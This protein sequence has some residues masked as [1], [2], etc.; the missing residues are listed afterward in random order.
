MRGQGAHARGAVTVAATLRSSFLDKHLDPASSLGEILFGLIMTLTFTLGAGLMLREEGREGARELLIATIGCNV[1]WGIIDGAL[2]MVGQLFERG[3][4]RRVVHAVREAP[5]AEAGVPLLAGEL[6]ELLAAVTTD[7]ERSALYRRIA[8][9][10][11]AA[12]LPAIGVTR[13][14]WLGGVASFFLVFFA[15]LPAAFPFLVFDQPYLALRV[16]NAL[17][18]GLL[19]Y[20]GFAWARHTVARPWLTGFVFLLGGVAL[21]AVAIALGG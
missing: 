13:A 11:R 3:R 19:F 12:T 8:E 14:D 1:A 2:Y 18:L 15:S 20:A 16:S 6:D 21:V 17:L 5:S 7:A 9:R 10:V 4:R